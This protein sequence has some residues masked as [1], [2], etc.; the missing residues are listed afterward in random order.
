[1]GT[2]K[3]C[4]NE[5]VLFGHAEHNAKTDGYENIYNFT[6]KTFVQSA[7]YMTT[8]YKCSLLQSYIICVRVSETELLSYATCIIKM[9][10]Q[11]G[12]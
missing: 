10:K 11:S 8:F 6:L 4:L 9:F 5:T 3:S 7:T 2:Q 12:P 1:M